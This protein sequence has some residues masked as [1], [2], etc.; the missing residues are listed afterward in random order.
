MSADILTFAAGAMGL[1]IALAWN[2][3]ANLAISSAFPQKTKLR[4]A[5]VHAAITT[6]VVGLVV[7]LLNYAHVKIRGPPADDGSVDWIEPFAAHGKFAGRHIDHGFAQSIANTA[8][9]SS[10]VCGGCCDRIGC[11]KADYA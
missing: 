8:G 10:C 1:T 7:V 2:N 4:S 5:M 3:V 6:A 11:G 9:A